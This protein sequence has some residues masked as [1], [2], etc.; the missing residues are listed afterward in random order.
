[1]M[2]FSLLFLIILIFSGCGD[3]DKEAILKQKINNLKSKNITLNKHI[4][5]LNE[6]ID[7]LKNKNKIFKSTL[8]KYNIKPINTNDYSG[9][10][11]YNEVFNNE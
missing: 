7:S 10:R 3:E 8:S 1:M 11:L 9:N 4:Q 2:N 5:K 6:N